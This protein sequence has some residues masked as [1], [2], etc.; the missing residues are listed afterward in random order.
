MKRRNLIIQWLGVL[1][2]LVLLGACGDNGTNN[3]GNSNSNNDSGEDV[4]T[5][6]VMLYNYTDIQGK[7]I[8]SYGDYLEEHFNVKFDYATVGSSEEDHITALENLIASGVDAIISG[9][10]TAL[11]QSI[12]LSEQANV[13]YSVAL[14]EVVEDISSDYLVG[15]LSQFGENPEKL[16]AQYAEAAVEAGVKNIAVTTF[17]EFA[18]YDAVPII[19]GFRERIEELDDEVTVYDTVTHMFSPNDVVDAVTSII[20]D[21]PEVD[22]IFGLG[23]GMDFVYPAVL[24]STKPDIKVLALGY[25]DSTPAAL[26][27]DSVIMA[28]FNNYSQIMASMFAR[29]YDRLNGHEYPDGQLNGYIDYPTVQETSDVE[30]IQTYVIPDNKSEGSV[31]IEELKEVMRTFNENATWEDLQE[32]TNR[33]IDEIKENRQ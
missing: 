16:G 18:F 1:L 17:P 33:T 2:L 9:Y 23:S 27:N 8:R 15:G 21:N 4:V 28:G 31:T 5:I 32:L 25:N 22:A 26:E 11:E 19:N 12:A 24:N 20:S 30:D 6:G 7:E 29:L 14:G 3:T 13:Y 10:D